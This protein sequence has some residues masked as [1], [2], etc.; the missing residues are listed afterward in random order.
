VNCLDSG[1]MRR[2]WRTL[3]AMIALT[4]R[5]RGHEGRAPGRRGLC[6]ACADLRVY[7]EQRLMRCPF[8][9]GKPTCNNC[10]VHCYRPEM[11][12]RVREVMVYAGPRMLVRHPVLAL[13]HLLVDER[14]PAPERPA[15]RRAAG[16]PAATSDP[17]RS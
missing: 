8:G 10:Q 11:R 7:A 13:L 2:E 4:C 9:E 5:G 3:E 12:Q 15:R 14:R 16:N 6:H 1:R 17:V